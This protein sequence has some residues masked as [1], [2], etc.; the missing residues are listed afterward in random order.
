M[1]WK[2]CVFIALANHLEMWLGKF[3]NAKFPFADSQDDKKGPDNIKQNYRNRV[4]KEVWDNDEFKALEDEPEAHNGIGTHSNRKFTSDKA[5]KAG[6]DDPQVEHRGRWVGEKGRRAVNKHCIRIEDK[7]TDACVAALLC[8][9]GP[10]KCETKEG[11]VIADEFLF[12]VV[13]PNIRTRFQHDARL[14]RVLALA[15]PW[16]MFNN[17]TTNLLPVPDVARIRHS[18]GEHR[19]MDHD[20]PVSKMLLEVAKVGT[21]LE[22]IPIN[23]MGQQ[24]QQQQEQQGVSLQAN[25]NRQ[26]LAPVQRMNR[27]NAEQFQAI[28][29][30]QTA[31]RQWMQQQFSQV[32]T[33]QRRCG[34]TIERASAR[35][36]PQRQQANLHQATL[37]LTHQRQ[38]PQANPLPT[39]GID[40]NAKLQNNIRTLAE[41]WAECQ[42]GVGNNKSAKAFTAAERNRHDTP[43]KMKHSRRQKIWRVQGCLC[44][45]GLTIE[46]V[47]AKIIDVFDAEN[48]TSIIMQ[49]TRDQKNQSC[50]FIGS[51]RFRPRLLAQAQR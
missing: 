38:R 37:Q 18:F 35:Q 28:R 27:N 49:M 29:A 20:Q 30:E 12:S 3:P 40:A 46:A 44:D 42:F 23:P 51:Q 41:F 1:D 34:G 6:A 17:E 9:G 14:C 45:S 19:G 33:N 24:H 43:H 32:N 31:Q 13:V 16:A 26:L 48:P 22:I 7:C 10:V 50:V 5:A 8:D 11:L 25:D 2:T 21:R 39:C 47:N 15:R 36:H 4:E